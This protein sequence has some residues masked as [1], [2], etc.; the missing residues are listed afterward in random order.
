LCDGP[1][2]YERGNRR[3]GERAPCSHAR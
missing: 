1:R 2:R 3:N